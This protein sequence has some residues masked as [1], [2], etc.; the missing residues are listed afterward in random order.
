MVMEFYKGKAINH[1]SCFSFVYKKRGQL[2]AILSNDSLLQTW[3]L[4]V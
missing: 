1:V 3:I 2:V 4:P